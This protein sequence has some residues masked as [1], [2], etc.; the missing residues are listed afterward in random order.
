ME[1]RLEPDLSHCVETRAKERYE[2]VLS[3]LLKASEED[4]GLADELELLRLFLES[5]D[6]GRLR[7]WCDEFFLAGR[8]VECILRSAHDPPGYEIEITPQDDG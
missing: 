2:K 4:A 3:A 5:A 7:N 1:I 8:P 6:F